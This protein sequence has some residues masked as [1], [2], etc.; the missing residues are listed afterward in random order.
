[1]G[2]FWGSPKQIKPLTGDG[3]RGV[4]VFHGLA[5]MF[6]ARVV[7]GVGLNSAFPMVNC[8]EM[9]FHILRGGGLGYSGRFTTS[10]AKHIY[11]IK[12]FFHASSFADISVTPQ[13]A[14]APILYKKSPCRFFY[15]DSI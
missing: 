11:Y 4:Y 7:S 13:F 1:V 10:P 15:S 8:R 5:K 2:T 6:R 9:D 14:L 3:P 12:D